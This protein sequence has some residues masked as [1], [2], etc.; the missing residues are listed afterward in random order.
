MD[1]QVT[2][3]A[4][5]FSGNCGEGEKC[6]GVG[7]IANLNTFFNNITIYFSK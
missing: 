6:S 1:I 4:A 7:I 5:V 3:R 2:I